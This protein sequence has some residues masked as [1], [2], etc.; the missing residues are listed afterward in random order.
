MQF[1][2][3]VMAT[4]EEQVDRRKA[5]CQIRSPPPM[6]IFGAKMEITQQDGSF[7]ACY[8]QNY[9]DQEEETE[10]VVHLRRPERI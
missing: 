4:V 3:E 5:G 6:V 7:C 10:H 2:E 1:G 9:K 8:H